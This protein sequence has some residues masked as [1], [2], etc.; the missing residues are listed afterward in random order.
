MTWLLLVVLLVLCAYAFSTWAAQSPPP[1]SWQGFA[2]LGPA[3][4]VALLGGAVAFI[5]KVRAG[6]ARR[7]NFVEFVGDMVTSA[8]SGL[9]FYWLCRGFEINE[10][11][12]AAVVGMAGHA[13]SRAL[14]MLE[15]W[16][17][18]KL[19]NIDLKGPKP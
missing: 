8:V 9:F 5:S 14:F 19:A 15:K 13:G 4:L 7:F 3:I 10:W 2:E 6:D 18:A 11:V 12:T 17:E 16:V 1:I